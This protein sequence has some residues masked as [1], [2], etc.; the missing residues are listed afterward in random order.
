MRKVRERVQ[1][2]ATAVVA[3]V[4]TSLYSFPSLSSP[5]LDPSPH[6]CTPRARSRALSRP[7]GRARACAGDRGRKRVRMRVCVLGSGFVG[8]A[9]GV[10]GDAYAYAGAGSGS[11]AGAGRVR[12]CAAAWTWARAWVSQPAS[13]PASR[14]RWRR[15][16]RQRTASTCVSSGGEQ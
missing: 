13:A 4:L 6:L 9:K 7:P 2:R 11:G 1:V 5:S 15:R 14:R 3:G 16:Q 8:T 10:V 12:G